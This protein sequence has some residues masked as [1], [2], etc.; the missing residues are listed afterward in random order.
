LER[1]SAE[2]DYLAQLA[3]AEGLREFLEAH[4]PGRASELQ[5]S[6]SWG[7]AVA[8][9]RR[10]VGVSRPSTQRVVSTAMETSASAHDTAAVVHSRLRQFLSAMPAAGID[11]LTEELRTV[12]PDLANMITQ[13]RE[14]MQRR[15]D[16]VTMAAMV[17]DSEW[18]R[19]L[20][21][22]LGPFVTPEEATGVLRRTA[23]Y[24]DRWGT[25]ESPLPLGPVP[26]AYEWEQQEQR[27]YIDRL[28]EQAGVSFPSPVDAPRW[29]DDP[30]TWEDR[31]IN[32][33]W[34]L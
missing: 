10:S 21:E 13:V 28:V 9:W 23:I 18:K 22:A 7:A 1:L 29:T 2:Y 27:A 32:V 15:M 19:N 14:R 34:Q 16:H 8:A 31:L 6:P 25:D 26:A 17:G 33:G 4:S 20:F 5:R 30:R 24:R 3:A 12:R 11:P